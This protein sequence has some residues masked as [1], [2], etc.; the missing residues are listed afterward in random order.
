LSSLQKNLS[1]EL[2]S[3]RNLVKSLELQLEE[4]NGWLDVV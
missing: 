3:Q 4:S 2:D 1:E